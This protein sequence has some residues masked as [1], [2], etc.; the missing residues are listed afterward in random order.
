VLKNF[1]N[2]F[3]RKLIKS[4]EFSIPF[5]IFATKEGFIPLGHANAKFFGF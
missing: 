4:L 2:K 3:E 1:L 5:Y